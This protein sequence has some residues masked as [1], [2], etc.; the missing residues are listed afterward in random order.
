MDGFLINTGKQRTILVL[1]SIFLVSLYL[2]IF[3][4][5]YYFKIPD[6]YKYSSRIKSTVIENIIKTCCSCFLVIGTYKGS[7]WF[8]YLLLLFI[9]FDLIMIVRFISFTLSSP[10]LQTDLNLN[11]LHVKIFVYSLAIIFFFFSKS[12]KAFFEYQQQTKV[13]TN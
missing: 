11:Y 1:A 8:K 13:S 5:D 9:A 3:T 7:K 12:F 4:A 10:K 6:H 2:T